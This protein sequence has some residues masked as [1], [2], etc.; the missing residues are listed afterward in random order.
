M[1]IGTCRRLDIPED[2]YYAIFPDIL[3]GRAEAFYLNHIGPEKR[4]DEIYY[5][6]DSHFSTTMNHAQYFTDWTT[7]SF[8]RV[9]S[10]NAEKQPIEVLEILLDKLQLAQ[11]AL[12]KGFE[13]EVALY[14]SVV[15]ACR[16]VP[17]LSPALIHQKPTCEA[18][19]E[20]DV[21]GILA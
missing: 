10:E 1:F 6:M 12:G 14:T 16:G 19:F 4:W 21:K 17:E 13:G 15:R 20:R 18:L 11:R 8:A 7:T 3:S 9:K 5:L 2:Q